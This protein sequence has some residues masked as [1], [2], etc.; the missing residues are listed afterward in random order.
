MHAAGVSVEPAGAAS[1][2]DCRVIS[3]PSAGEE[4]GP[5]R[6]PP[7]ATGVSF[8]TAASGAP[9]TTPACGA[10]SASTAVADCANARPSLRLKRLGCAIRNSPARATAM[11]FA[12]TERVRDTVAQSGHSPLQPV[13]PTVPRR[14]LLV[15]PAA[16]RSGRLL[17][18]SRLEQRVQLVER[19][20]ALGA[21]QKRHRKSLRPVHDQ[22]RRERLPRPRIAP[23]AARGGR[24]GQ[25]A[26]GD[27]LRQTRVI[28][29][30]EQ[31]AYLIAHSKKKER[32][33]VQVS[34]GASSGR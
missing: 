9:S 13:V 10:S 32:S 28:Q 31:P 27:E 7:P 8:A 25:S 21:D 14:P 24:V 26:V 16:V 29:R 15:P 6:S 4:D 1:T 23:L 22:D 33:Y 3:Q 34:S 20:P 18:P 17:P 11:S 19:A 12:A 2:C 30:R 5:R